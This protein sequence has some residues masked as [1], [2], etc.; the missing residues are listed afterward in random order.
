[1]ALFN[2]RLPEHLDT[3]LVIACHHELVVECSEEQAEEVALFLEEVMVA[4]IDEILNPEL[5][6]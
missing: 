3:K 1:M 5:G 6:R 2:E 4:G